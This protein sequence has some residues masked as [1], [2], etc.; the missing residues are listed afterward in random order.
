MSADPNAA[1]DH[2]VLDLID[3]SPTGAVPATPA[4]QDAL[5]R[6]YASHQ[7]YAS[8]D[9]KNG[10][11]T[12]RSLA[13][14]PSFLA[15]NLADFMAG[16]IDA[17]ALEPNNA[18]YDRYVQSLPA[19]L[20]ARA[21][22]FRI[23][24]AGKVAHHRAKHGAAVVHDPLHTLFLVPGAGPNPGLPGNYLHGSVF[25]VG[26]SLEAGAWAVHV[27]DSDDGAALFETPALADALATMQDVIASAPFHLEELGALGFRRN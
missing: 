25:H 23:P 22:S 16:Q 13:A 2:T 19:A 3:H 17:D 12:V 1:F 9:H 21:E 26:P 14:A 15:A 6:L 4:Y 11:V 20:R 27:H 8:A 24:V 10:H 18:I 5:K 7:A